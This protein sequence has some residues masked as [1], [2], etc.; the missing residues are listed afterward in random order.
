MDVTTLKRFRQNACNDPVAIQNLGLC[1]PKDGSSSQAP[2]PPKPRFP[3]KAFP[4]TKESF[5]SE[6]SPQQLRP[7]G[8]TRPSSESSKLSITLPACPRR[9]ARWTWRNTLSIRR[10]DS[11]RKYI[12]QYETSI[13][14][15]VGPL[16]IFVLLAPSLQR[17]GRRTLTRARHL[18]GAPSQSNHAPSGLCL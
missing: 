8:Q 15:G 1:K 16:S 13:A 14:Y 10:T 7:Q 2:N 18:F 3:P 12:K 6:V 17:N 11:G 9:T 5:A 4:A